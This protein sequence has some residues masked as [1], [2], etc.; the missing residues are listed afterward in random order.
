MP[1]KPMGQKSPETTVGARLPPSNTPIPRLTHSRPKWHPD[2]VSHFA[3][4]HF[5]TDQQTH[6]L[7]DGLGWTNSAHVALIDSNMQ[8]ALNFFTPLACDVQTDHSQHSDGGD[9][10]NF[11]QLP[12]FR[13]SLNR[14]KVSV[15]PSVHPS[16][17]KYVHPYVHNQTQCSHK[18]NSGIR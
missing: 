9:P 2:P 14:V 11:E 6:Q 10:Y 12:I 3:T 15:P 18:P 13:S 16:V 4:V 5:Q 8:T 17:R 1:F 7:T